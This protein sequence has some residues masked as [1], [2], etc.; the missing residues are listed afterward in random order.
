MSSTISPVYQPRGSDFSSWP[1]V[2]SKGSLSTS[3]ESTVRNS[4]T[5]PTSQNDTLKKDSVGSLWSGFTSLKYPDSHSF[6]FFSQEDGI[7]RSSSSRSTKSSTDCS[8]LSSSSS[9]SNL[10]PPISHLEKS[11]PNLNLPFL[12]QGKGATFSKLPMELQLWQDKVN[13]LRDEFEDLIMFFMGAN[14]ISEGDYVVESKLY[15]TKLAAAESVLS[16]L[17]V[18]S[19]QNLEQVN[20]S[21]FCSFTPIMSLADR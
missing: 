2:Q 12:L 5:N 4:D 21:T 8:S 9:S 3:M 13:F 17:K 7:Y 18:I 14:Q 15:T 19:W 6:T 16:A 1:R 11:V 10:S 20:P